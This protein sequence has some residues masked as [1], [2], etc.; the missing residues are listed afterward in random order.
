MIVLE[1]AHEFQLI[2][3]DHEQHGHILRGK[4]LADGIICQVSF[5]IME[6]LFYNTKTQKTT[7]CCCEF[8]G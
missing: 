8:V 7:N 3:K 4:F 2:V 6:E 1:Q 5:I